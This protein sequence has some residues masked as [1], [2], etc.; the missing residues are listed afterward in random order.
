MSF[1][2]FFIDDGLIERFGELRYPVWLGASHS[3]M[4]TNRRDRKLS[5]LL[6][7]EFSV[8]IHPNET[9]AL[10]L[11]WH[12]EVADYLLGC[13]SCSL[14]EKVPRLRSVTMLLMLLKSVFNLLGLLQV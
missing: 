2:K 12:R 4:I 13:C 5:K 6:K 8:N 3:L 9:R 11:I 7:G 10:T 14:F 1:F